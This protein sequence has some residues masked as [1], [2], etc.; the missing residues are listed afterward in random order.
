[1]TFERRFAEAL[2]KS[3]PDRTLAG[4]W[5]HFRDV[6]GVGFCQTDALL[7]TEKEI[8]IFECKLTD[9]DQGRTQLTQL[10]YPVVEMACGKKVRGVIVSRHLTRTTDIKNTTNILADALRIPASMIP[11]LHWRERHP[12]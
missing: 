5:F 2:Q 1:M 4:Q 6:N 7:V 8:I 11:I 10:Y 12:L 9:T 3:W